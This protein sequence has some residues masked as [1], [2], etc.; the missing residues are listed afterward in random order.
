MRSFSRIAAAVA[1]ALVGL[2]AAQ[3][4]SIYDNQGPSIYDGT[5]ESKVRAM[6]DRQTGATRIVGDAMEVAKALGFDK[7]PPINADGKQLKEIAIRIDGPSRFKDEEGNTLSISQVREREERRKKIFEMLKENGYSWKQRKA[8]HEAEKRRRAPGYENVPSD[9]YEENERMRKYAEEHGPITTKHFVRPGMTP[10]M[11]DALDD[12]SNV[13]KRIKGKWV[14]VDKTGKPVLDR[15]RGTAPKP[16]AV[17]GETLSTVVT[18]ISK[19]P[20]RSS[21]VA[22]VKNEAYWKNNPAYE[23]PADQDLVDQ[24]IDGQV[25]FK[26]PR[27]AGGDVQNIFTELSTSKDG[28]MQYV[29]QFRLGEKDREIIEQRRQRELRDKAGE[30]AARRLTDKLFSPELKSTRRSVEDPDA[31][32]TAPAEPPPGKPVSANDS[33]DSGPMAHLAGRAVSLLFGVKTARAAESEELSGFA[34]PDGREYRPEKLPEWQKDVREKFQFPVNKYIQEGGKYT[35]IAN[36]IAKQARDLQEK[37]AT[38]GN[39]KTD[40]QSF[41]DDLLED[42]QKKAERGEDSAAG[43]RTAAEAA[44]YAADIIHTTGSLSIAEFEDDAKAIVEMLSSNSGK[45]FIDEMRKILR[46]YPEI[47]DIAPN[48]DADLAKLAAERFGIGTPP[49][50]P[51]GS[52]T[53]IFV[54]RSLEG[55]LKGIIEKAAHSGRKDVVL[56]FR[57]VPEGQN[58]NNGIMDLQKLAQSITPMPAI[59]IDPNLFKLYD[60]KNVPTVVRAKAQRTQITPQGPARHG[61]EM[62]AK[63]EGLDNDEWLMGQIEAGERGDLGLR[64]DV[65]E[66]SEPDLI[67][68]MKQRAMAIDWEAKRRAAIKNA[69]KNQKFVVLPTAQEDKV[70]RIDPT[71]VVEED[72]MDLAG[73]YIRKAGD[74]VNPLSIRPFD[75]PLLVFNPLSKEELERVDMFLS[76]NRLAGGMQPILIATQIN[77]EVGWDSYKKVT[78]HFDRHVFMLT[79]DVQKTFKIEA[80]PSYVTADHK[81]LVFLVKELGPLPPKTGEGR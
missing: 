36:E 16:K 66:I 37:G 73:N 75:I 2:S 6:R 30:R 25:T 20:A 56:V 67:E 47:Y 8:E 10:E 48:A 44:Q 80:T 70:R 38:A 29:R 42:A 43:A 19:R 40:A 57:G 4:A 51:K 26:D 12:S 77:K 65:R 24:I 78:D 18:T 32:E 69:W 23:K 76:R 54:S 68:V 46:A 55:D 50:D 17:R 79:E 62:V 5:H 71:I 52:A 28:K 34:S 41:I 45:P 49:D 74:R 14:V 58:I 15:F 64:G 7:N 9:W 3:A 81:D 60:V 53:L 21:D 11:S 31:V 22:I 59:I 1:A 72:I 61:G 35:D 33:G 63:V 39:E 27:L 13:Y